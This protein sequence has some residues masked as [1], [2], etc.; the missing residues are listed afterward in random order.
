[1]TYREDIQAV[2]SIDRI[3]ELGWTPQTPISQA[4]AE[5]SGLEFIKYDVSEPLASDIR[6]D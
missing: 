4:F 3:Q 2:F 6:F 1:M 5:D